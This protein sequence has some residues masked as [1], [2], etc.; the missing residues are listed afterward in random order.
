MARVGIYGGS[1]NPPHVGHSLAAREMTD[2]L[3]LDRLLIVP[4]AV[5]PH[6]ALPD[7]SPG[8]AD[9]LELCRLAF[10]GIP[11][12]EVCDLEL[13]REGPSYT[14][15]TLRALR[16]SMPDDELFLM[17]GTDMLLSFDLWREPEEIA[18]LAT[19]AVVRREESE[20]VWDEVRRKAASL[21]RT[22]PARI[23]LVENRCVQVSSTTVRRLLALGAP[24]ALE[25]AVE[26][27]ILERGW[28]LSGCDLKNLPFDRLSEISLSLHDEK[29]RPHV[30]GTSQTARALALRWGADPD[31]AARAGI[32]HDI[33]KALGPSE[34]LHICRKYDMVLTELQRDNPKLLHAKT[35]AAVA[36]AV[37]GECEAVCEAIYWHTTGKANMSLLEKIIYIADYMEPN[38]SFPGVE[39]LRSLVETDLD[40]AVFEGLDQSVR[41]LRKQ[42][43]IVDP[44]SLSA[45]RCYHPN[46][47]REE[48]K[49]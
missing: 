38:R 31:L 14:I 19:L 9:R 27:M 23:V 40:A 26:R 11:K 18:R 25:P 39:I 4:A 1:F 13:R 15:D 32:L 28:Y 5:P 12:A 8:A 7:G 45:W 6:K 47:D 21:S 36:R 30:L 48:Q 22:L 34:Q 37:F 10:A 35:G 44:D 16:Q 33:T 42:G 24:W 3:G 17:M 41:L 2:R 43:R 29:R 20:A 46:K 49:A